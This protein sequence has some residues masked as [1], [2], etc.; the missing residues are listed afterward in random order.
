MPYGLSPGSLGS[1][2]CVCFQ[3]CYTLHACR[4]G[5][6]K[7]KAKPGIQISRDQRNKRKFVTIVCGLETFGGHVRSTFGVQL[8]F[9]ALIPATHL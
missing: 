7:M 9:P 6:V 4:G 1:L 8:D 2:H 3:L 5:K